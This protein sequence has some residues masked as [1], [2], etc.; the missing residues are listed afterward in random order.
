MIDLFASDLDGTLL[1]K[2]HQ[3]D[4]IIEDTI[5][6]VLEHGRYFAVATGRNHA[7]ADFGPISQRLYKL[8]LNGGAIYSPEEEL[9]HSYPID[10]SVIREA[11]KRFGDKG[12]TFISPDASYTCI[13]EEEWFAVIDAPESQPQGEEAFD[14]STAEYFHTQMRKS[15]MFS[16]NLEDIL[17][18]DICKIEGSISNGITQA[19]ID[20]FVQEYKDFIVDAPCDEGMVEITRSDCNKGQAVKWLASY[21]HVKE[22][23]VAVYGNGG[24][25]IAM[26]QAFEHSYAPSTSIPEVLACAREI[27]GPF[28]NY[29]VAGHIKQ[30][31]CNQD[32]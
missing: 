27:L 14:E 12:M 11:L 5:I 19:D 3:F 30:I 32:D 9:L 20:V 21:L 31:V 7:L 6:T 15:T 26:M 24:N 16:Q 28:Q 25:D 10:K 13:S 8:C 2:S 4:D 23:H 1:G 17:A 29:S 22:D 18:Q